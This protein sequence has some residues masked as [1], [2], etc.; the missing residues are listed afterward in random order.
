MITTNWQNIKEKYISWIRDNTFIEEF[1]GSN[2][3]KF[4]V[5]FLDRH[6]D[7]IEIYVKESNG[8]YF[9]TDDGFTIDDLKMSGLEI[10]SSPKRDKIFKMT[11]NGFGVK[12]GEKQNLFVEAN[13]IN[14][15]QKKHSL[16]QAILAVNDM[17]VLSQ[18]NV[19]SFFKE[20]VERYFN[21]EDIIFTKDIKIPGKSGFDHNFDFIIPHT[22]SKPERLIKA[23][24]KADRTAIESAIFS[25]SDVSETREINTENIALYND[26][27]LQP[28]ADTR[29]ALKNYRITAIPWSLKAQ[30]K[31]RFVTN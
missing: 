3:A 12:V 29:D 28:S 10:G 17:Y 15:G 22:K 9:L 18:E 21:S 6:N 23:I 16:I 26:L 24:N 20:D 1:P 13:S 11:I 25:F 7:N 4:S 30:Y 14:I 8:T 31:E 5:P 19:L 2:F 27:L